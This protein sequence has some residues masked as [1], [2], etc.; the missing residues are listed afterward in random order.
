MIGT[1]FINLIKTFSPEEIKSFEKFIMSPYF[2]SVKNYVILFEEIKKF[3]PEFND[4]KFTNDYIYKKLFKGKPFNKQV[5]WN[6]TSGL[7]KLAVEFLIHKK[8]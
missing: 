5:M 1:K 7:E 8:V 2:N 4:S 6:I 3:Y